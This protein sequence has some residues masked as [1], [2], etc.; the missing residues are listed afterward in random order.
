MNAGM[1]NHSWGCG[2]NNWGD[3][4]SIVAKKDTEGEDL[5]SGASTEQ[6]EFGFTY[7]V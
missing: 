6:Q 5:C 7:V 3:G 1:E 2:M 4:D